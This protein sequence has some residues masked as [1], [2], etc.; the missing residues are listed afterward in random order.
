MRD[1]GRFELL[2]Q[3][4]AGSVLTF[5]RRRIAAADADDVVAD[6][7][8]AA[9]RRWDEVPRD[10]LPWLLGIAR[11]ALANRHRGEARASALRDRLRSEPSAVPSRQ[12]YGS[13]EATLA[14]A[15]R[16]QSRR[17]GALVA[18][19]MG[20]AGSP[21]DRR[22]ARHLAGDGSGQVTPRA[23]SSDPRCF[24]PAHR[25]SDSPEI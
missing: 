15:A 20:G 10:P 19:C 14:D 25:G 2:Y 5:A 16:A 18:G 11:G 23:G 4:H 12:G 17:S 13:V 8:L 21:A 3:E 7:F 9:W 1:H 24:S 6:V 22:D